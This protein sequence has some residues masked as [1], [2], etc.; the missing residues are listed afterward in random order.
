MTGEY[1]A[2]ACQKHRCRASTLNQ[3][4]DSNGTSDSQEATPNR[5]LNF[6]H[7][8]ALHRELHLK[9]NGCILGKRETCYSEAAIRP[10]EMRAGTVFMLDPKDEQVMPRERLAPS[11]ADI[12]DGVGMGC[13]THGVPETLENNHISA[14]IVCR[15]VLDSHVFDVMD[16]THRIILPMQRDGPVQS[17]M[18]PPK[19]APRQATRAAHHAFVREEWS[20]LSGTY[21]EAVLPLLRAEFASEAWSSVLKS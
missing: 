18:H 3:H 11:D 8:R 17:Y 1:G 12:P 16:E 7:T 13:W 10:V 21:A 15:N 14:G 19:H 4:R 5:T 9:K 2:D 6:G 20:L